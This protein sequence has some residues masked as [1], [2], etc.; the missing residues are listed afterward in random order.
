MMK[1]KNVVVARSFFSKGLGLMFKKDFNSAL[2]IDLG[3]QTRLGA[4]IHMMFMRFAIDVFFVD[5]NHRVVD[6]ARNVQPWTLSVLPKKAC[7]YVVETKPNQVKARVGDK[8][9]W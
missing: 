2:V 1:L 6:I 9:E 7:R 8:L 5:K 3:F 4:G